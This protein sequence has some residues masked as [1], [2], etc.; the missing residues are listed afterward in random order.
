MHE[1]SF[2]GSYLDYLRVAE[3]V[4]IGVEVHCCKHILKNNK[5]FMLKQIN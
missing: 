2:E 3:T 4:L 1:V 5:L